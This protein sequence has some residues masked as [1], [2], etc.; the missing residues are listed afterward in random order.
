MTTQEIQRMMDFI[1]RSHADSAIRMDRCDEEIEKVI[2][3]V[4]ENAKAI[5]ENRADIRK[6]TRDQRAYEK[7]L[8]D[9]EKSKR[10]RANRLEGL[11]DIMKIL[12]RL[13]AVQSKRLDQLEKVR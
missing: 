13:T 3:T 4:R 11:R 5:R 2:V 12:S 7:R 6:L 8:R 10:H 9:S 1:L